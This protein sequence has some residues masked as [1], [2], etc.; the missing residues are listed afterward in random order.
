L[1]LFKKEKHWKRAT[2]REAA[3][4]VGLTGANR[5]NRDVPELSAKLTVRWSCGFFPPADYRR[6][7]V[8][9][10]GESLGRAGPAF[11]ASSSVASVASCSKKK[12]HRKGAVSRE[13]VELCW[14]NKGLFYRVR[15]AGP[16]R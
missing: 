5:A 7:G 3:A 16:L 10:G 4:L 9:I 13:A 12:N 8:Q 6:C 2:S 15:S 11:S 1:L 14:F